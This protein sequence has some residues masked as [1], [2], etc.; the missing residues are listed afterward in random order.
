[1][2]NVVNVITDMIDTSKQRFAT[3][4]FETQRTWQRI[5]PNQLLRC[6]RKSKLVLLLQSLRAEQLAHQTAQEPL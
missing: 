4:L 2:M 6:V 3:S 5:I 1:M